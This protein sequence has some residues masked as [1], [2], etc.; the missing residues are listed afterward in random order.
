MNRV[1]PDTSPEASL[2]L[3]ATSPRAPLPGLPR[4]RPGSGGI[5]GLIGLGVVTAGVVAVGL[6]AGGAPPLPGLPDAGPFVRAALPGVRVVSEIAAVFVVGALLAAAAL[7]PAGGDRDRAT[8]I[9]GRAAGWWALL[10]AA[11]VVLTVADAMGQPLPSALATLAPSVGRLSVALAWLVVANV[12]ALVWIG[13]RLDLKPPLLLAASL[14]GVAPVALTGHSSSGGDHDIASDS[15]MLHVVA[16]SVWVGGLVALLVIIRKPYAAAAA[17]VFSTVALVCWAAVA[18]TGVV[19]ASL[20]LTFDDLGT[21]YGVL[22]VAKTAAVVL[23]GFF[24]YLHRQRTLSRLAEGATRPLLRL[25]AIEVLLMLATIGL[26]VGLSRTPGP[27][28]VRRRLSATEILIGYPLPDAPALS[29]LLTAWRPDLVFGTAAVVA[30]LWYLDRL[31]R[32]TD[33]WPVRRTASWLSGCALL[34]VATCVLGEYEP[35]MFSVHIVMQALV[36]LAVP[37]LLAHGK[38]LALSGPLA[39]WLPRPGLAAS[40]VVA[41]P[42]LLYAL[43]FFDGLAGKHWAR[44]AILA[45]SLAAGLGLFARTRRAPLLVVAGVYAAIGLLLLTRNAALGKGFYAKLALE[46]PHD[47]LADQQLAGWFAVA[48]GV[49]LAAY[50]VVTRRQA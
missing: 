48:A 8:G 3:G 2:D 29:R 46:W 44:L 36:G 47:L 18:V 9:A 39:V 15:L 20:R 4:S 11:M 49:V 31:R 27:L 6:T 33:P 45:C 1:R 50:T 25:G 14:V 23:L 30:T 17:R 16:V 10:S 12:A 21:R 32:R 28:G 35:A 13:T 5:A 37:L 7:I 26:A 22:I 24:G 43:G 40:A 34:F 41:I 38:P 19:N 42:V